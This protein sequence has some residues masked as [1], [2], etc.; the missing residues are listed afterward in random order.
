MFDPIEQIKDFMQ[1][2]CPYN[3][4][5]RAIKPGDYAI[6][7]MTGVYHV[8]T[9][10]PE[11]QKLN[12]QGYSIYF[13]VAA[14]N[15]M[16]IPMEV[17]ACWLDIDFKH[18]DDGI[19]N[20]RTRTMLKLISCGLSPQLIVFSGHG[21]HA[22][23]CLDKDYYFNDIG[24]KARIETTN[25]KLAI[26]F[27]GDKVHN[28]DRLMRMPGFYNMKHPEMPVMAE[29]VYKGQGSR[30][31]L[32]QVEEFTEH[33]T[34]PS[35]SIATLSLIDGNNVNKFPSRSERDF[36]VVVDMIKAGMLFDEIQDI[37]DSS[38]V[39]DKYREKGA[40]SDDYLTKTYNAAALAANIET[41]I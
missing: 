16:K 1:M 38:P 23:W 32:E 2:V 20:I 22:Y 26:M 28:I 12:A 34:L 11:L 4:L 24:N 19:V 31:T 13:G 10:Y 33:I 27:H 7:Y 17:Q 21:L 8:D 30:W 36:A 14:R 35:L 37:F 29:I 39:G 5:I 3:C 25:K 6:D 40:H 41:E 9:F 18:F 15:E